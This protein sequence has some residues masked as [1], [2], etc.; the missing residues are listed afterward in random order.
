MFTTPR[1]SPRSWVLGPRLVPLKSWVPGARSQVPGPG[2]VSLRL[3]GGGVGVVVVVVVF[4]PPLTS[5][6]PPSSPLSSPPAGLRYEIL[7]TDKAMIL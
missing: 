7:S 6:F 4:V 3:A 5:P 2:L 1:F